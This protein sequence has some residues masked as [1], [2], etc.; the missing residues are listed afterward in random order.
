MLNWTDPGADLE[1]LIVK[2]QERALLR[3]CRIWKSIRKSQG[4]FMITTEYE[5]SSR[6]RRAH[7]VERTANTSRSDGRHL[8]K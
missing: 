4:D 2:P 7:A 8:R 1:L 6:N 3:Q 5:L